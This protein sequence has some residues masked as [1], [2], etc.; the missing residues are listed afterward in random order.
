MLEHHYDARRAAWDVDGPAPVLEGAPSTPTTLPGFASW[1]KRGGAAMAKDGCLH[2]HQVAEIVRQPAIDAKTLDKKRDLDVWPL[3]ENVGLVLERDD[4][5]R[6]AEVL[7]GSAA[8]RAGLKAGDRLAAAGE[9]KLFGQAD[10]RGVLHRGPSG[11]G[12][13]ELRWWRASELSSAP[14]ELRDGLRKTVLGR[15]MSIS[16]A[17]SAAI[18]FACARVQGEQR[19]KLGIAP[20]RWRFNS[21]SARRDDWPAQLPA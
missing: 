18:G 10:L 15:R 17:T 7:A 14:L 4:G 19:R 8:S 5:L 3:P 2:C 20:G 11:A 9:R 12:S 6:V 13:V 1:S 16:Q 21:G